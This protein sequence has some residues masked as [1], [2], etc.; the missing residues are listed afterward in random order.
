MRHKRRQIALF[1]R[2]QLLDELEHQRF[3]HLGRCANDTALQQQQ[4][5]YGVDVN[6]QQTFYSY[7]QIRD[8]SFDSYAHAGALEFGVQRGDQLNAIIDRSIKLQCVHLEMRKNFENFAAF[9]EAIF[10]CFVLLV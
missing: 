9:K 6:Q 8:E 5:R 4:H 3:Y 7:K 10:F 2:M 1:H